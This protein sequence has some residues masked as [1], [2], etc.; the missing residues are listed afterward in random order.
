[1]IS[2]GSKHILP[3]CLISLVFAFACSKQEKASS[4]PVG[5][6]LSVTL[7]P[8]QP[9][10]QNCLEAEVSGGKDPAEF[11]WGLNG[12]ILT[13]KKE[14][15]LC[16]EPLRKGDVVSVTVRKGGEESRATVTIMNSPPRITSH[17]IDPQRVFSGTDIAVIPEAADVDGDLVSFAYKWRINEEESL[18]DHDSTL[19]GDR[20]RKGDRIGVDITPF[21]GEAEG[22]VY[23]ASLGT[24]PNAPPEFISIPPRLEGPVYRYQVEAKDSDGDHL[25]YALEEA[26][27][28]MTISAS[29]LVT[30]HLSPEQAG[31]H[32]VLLSARDEGGL[33]CEQEFIL[34]ISF[35]D[36]TSQ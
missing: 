19:P 9:V 22:P 1:M 31:D 36:S 6:N 32:R 13:E 14:H 24:V 18:W 34:S 10:A 16:K 5:E 21:D 33:S 11:R 12:E 3:L 2:I 8:A 29:G 7:T 25:A 26:P 15:N 17:S 35:A 23:T 28:G 4:K 20:L 27:A 30:W